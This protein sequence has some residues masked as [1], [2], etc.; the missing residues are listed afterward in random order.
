MSD[1]Q[2]GPPYWWCLDHA[3]VEG[4]DGCPNTVR[5]GPYDTYEDA[6]AALEHARE[7]TEAWDHDPKWNDVDD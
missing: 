1:E 6:A 3:R 2:L 5:L 7:R 4:N